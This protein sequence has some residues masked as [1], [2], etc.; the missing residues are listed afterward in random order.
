M[1]S[2]LI[3]MLILFSVREDVKEE[4]KKTCWR[5]GATNLVNLEKLGQT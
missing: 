5:R 3:L 2:L 1:L 4:G